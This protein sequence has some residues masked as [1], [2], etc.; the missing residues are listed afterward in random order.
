MDIHGN[1]WKSTEVHRNLWKSMDIFCRFS[2]VFRT[3]FGTPF[4]WENGAQR[5]S[6]G[7]HF[8]H[9]W[10]P[11]LSLFLDLCVPKAC[12]DFASCRSSFLLVLLCV[13]T[14]AS[15]TRGTYSNNS[16]FSAAGGSPGYGA[17]WGPSAIQSTL[18]QISSPYKFFIC[19]KRYVCIFSLRW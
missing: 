13:R 10:A 2:D 16:W 19:S 8:W 6:L 18:G 4:Q 9:L 5:V 17:V 3:F 11:I 14:L 15:S 12:L 7:S 1:P